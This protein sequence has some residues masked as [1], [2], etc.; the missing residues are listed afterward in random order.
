[1]AEGVVVKPKPVLDEVRL[2]RLRLT[3]ESRYPG[4]E[5][6]KDP[7]FVANEA[8]YKRAAAEKAKEL[9][10][11]DVF[12]DL[13]TR[14][15]VDELFARCKQAAQAGGNLLYLRIPSKGDL[16]LLEERIV[17]LPDYFR[18]FFELLYGRAP[19]L[20]RLG[21]YL[22]RVRELGAGPGSLT[23]GWTTYLL[24]LTHPKEA[25]FIRQ[26]GM[27]DFRERLDLGQFDKE[28]TAREYAWYLELAAATRESMSDLGE[29]DMIDVQ[30]L[31]YE[32]GC[33]RTWAW[34]PRFSGEGA[35]ANPEGL[36]V[37]P[38]NDLGD[39]REID[40]VAELD[41][42]RRAVLERLGDKDRVGW[43]K[44]GVRQPWSLAKD[45]REGHL[46]AVVPTLRD[47]QGIARVIGPYEYRPEFKGHHALPVEWV[48][49]QER[50]A[51][52]DLK[53]VAFFELDMPRWN[54]IEQG[55]KTGKTVSLLP[56][57][58]A[59][60]KV[61]EPA[62]VQEPPAGNGSHSLEQVA[63]ATGIAQEEL[64][65]WVAQLRRKGQAIIMGPPG[66]GK[67]FVARHLARYLTSGS[68]GRYE[69]VQFHPAY[70][71]EDFMEGLRPEVVD[72]T[73]HY[74]LQP[75]H[76]LKLCDEA[77]KDDV[78]T[79]VLLLDEV[80]RAPL[81]RVFGELM[82]LLE[83]REEEVILAN[84]T[85][86]S[87][88]PNVLL[89]G[90]MN[91]ADRSIALVDH[92]LR[93]RFAFFRLDPDYGVL[94]R[95]LKNSPLDAER[96]VAVLREVN[97]AIDDPDLS[98]GISFFLDEAIRKDPWTHLPLVWKTEI[99]PYLDEL[100]YADRNRSSLYRWDHVATRLGAPT[101][102]S[103]D[104]EPEEDE[105]EEDPGG[106]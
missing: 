10:A 17:P 84:G 2:R 30:S 49:L 76:F 35:G 37:L 6:I 65:T 43:R 16:A 31:W 11:R 14:G 99:W 47:I 62:P 20:D 64:E 50:R 103:D 90:T 21:A 25:I 48:D 42:R 34:R 102:E 69:V 63:W 66:T 77:R 5:S 82:Y 24:A 88:P 28:V 101:A 55:E 73:V 96:L 19:L 91:T 72:G 89:L 80:N 104:Q 12:E 27:K 9:L 8:G 94:R 106:D 51:T 1:M 54:A 67:T 92:A 97:Q 85:R 81:A 70:A 60:P 105:D 93:R 7:R 79:Y 3:L 100:F 87:I 78:G 32:A 33:F 38:W 13:L 95:A 83:Y 26:K 75:G 61:S 23:W 41:E 39:L 44:H 57:P 68:S 40:R 86:F 4:L 58:R 36:V 29:M 18:A 71:Y 52:Q 22:A 45:V 74:R 98:L 46:I 59:A 15:A 53:G 56:L